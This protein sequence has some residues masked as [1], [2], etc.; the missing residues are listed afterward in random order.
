MKTVR[1][2]ILFQ[3][4]VLVG[5]VA[6]AFGIKQSVGMG[7]SI[8]PKFALILPIINIVLLILAYKGIKADDD[9]VK[10]ADRLR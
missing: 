10:S 6:Y 9:L 3:V 4:I 1:L 2:N 5:M 7:S 8:T